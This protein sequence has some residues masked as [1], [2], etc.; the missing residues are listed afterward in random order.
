VAFRGWL[1]ALICCVAGTV[2]S[3]LYIDQPLASFFAA[4]VAHTAAGYWLDR[5]LGLLVVLPVAA[6]LFLLACGCWLISG[7]S[8][9]AWM[10]P[11]LPCAWSAT[12]ALAAE[13]AF[14][15]M[16]ARLPNGGPHACQFPS[17]TATI[18]VATATTIWLVAPRLR[19]LATILAAF[20][21]IAVVVTNGHWLSDVIAGAF[22]G[23]SIGWMTVLLLGA[24]TVN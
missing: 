5:L 8:L 14:K 9:A 21:S 1:L 11:V 7:R 17:G 24:K 23:L 2:A 6:L 12:W 16:F 18:S 20:A 13:F 15:Q 3:I 10:R 19:P 22:L 4:Q